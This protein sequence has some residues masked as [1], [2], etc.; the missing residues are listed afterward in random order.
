MR[1]TRLLAAAVTALAVAAVGCGGPTYHGEAKRVDATIRAYDHADRARHTHQLCARL[2]T[3]HYREAISGTVDQC[4]TLLRRAQGPYGLKGWS[5]LEVHGRVASAHISS[6][7]KSTGT[8]HLVDPHG[9]W[10][11]DGIDYTSLG[12]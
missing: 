10:L 4:A 2:L 8:M 11:V 3:A 6:S 1:S 5:H 7:D 12:S 9:R